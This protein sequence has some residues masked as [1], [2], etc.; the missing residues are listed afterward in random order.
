MQKWEY[1]ELYIDGDKFAVSSP[2]GQYL[3]DEDYKLLD[4]KGQRYK[5]NT[6]LWKSGMG[7]SG[8]LL[9]LLDKLGSEGWEA[10]GNVNT[11]QYS[12]ILLILKRPIESKLP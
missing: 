6:S 7:T 3:T 8:L 5:A 10:I 9:V 2:Q 11:G 4:P 1:I 12:D